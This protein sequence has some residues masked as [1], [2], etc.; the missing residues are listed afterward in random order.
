[1]AELEHQAE[2]LFREGKYPPLRTA[3][4]EWL[5]ADPQNARALHLRDQLKELQVQQQRFESAAKSRNQD[6]GSKALQQ[7][8]KLNPSDPHLAQLRQ[9]LS[10][11]EFKPLPAPAP[12]AAAPPPAKKSL[13]PFALQVEHGH[14]LGKCTGELR[15]DGTTVNYKTSHKDHGFT[16]PF[17]KITFTAD[18]NKLTLVDAAT[19]SQARTFKVRDAEQAK[20]F[21]RAW[22][23]LKGNKP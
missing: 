5:A 16:L 1:M 15:I 6:E 23:R 9:R 7:L 10:G 8:E 21:I 17:E 18:N 3:L 11:E 20:N 4:D 13:E 22:E 14:L 2:T 19:N 12:V